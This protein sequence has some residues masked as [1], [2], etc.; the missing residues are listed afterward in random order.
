L[1]KNRKEI[2]IGYGVSIVVFII[3][4]ILG[5]L[6][7][8]LITFMLLERLRNTLI[9][10]VFFIGGAIKTKLKIII[11]TSAA[12]ILILLIIIFNIPHNLNNS[13]RF[14]ESE[15][16][17]IVVSRIRNVEGQIVD[18]YEHLIFEKGTVEFAL[19]N[20]VLNEYS[21]NLTIARKIGAPIDSGDLTTIT[22]FGRYSNTSALILTR[23][24]S[25]NV[26]VNR[27]SRRMSEKRVIELI[28]KILSICGI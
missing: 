1:K 16:I 13:L 3:F 28:D 7:A 5:L 9:G 19:I 18:E 27:T 11:P 24:S 15:K 17:N 22:I 14:D 25:S 8:L 2:T 20:D 23:T 26:M 4:P 12:V 6:T 21:Y 10:A